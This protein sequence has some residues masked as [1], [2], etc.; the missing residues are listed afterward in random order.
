MKA[1]VYISWPVKAWSIPDEKVTVLRE[2][3]PELD[4]VHA[5]T[6]RDAREGVESFLEKR[7]AKFPGKVSK[8]MPEF[9]PWWEPRQFE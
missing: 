7:A 9:F 6:E 1:L 5:A 8:D 2:R 4:F 3:F